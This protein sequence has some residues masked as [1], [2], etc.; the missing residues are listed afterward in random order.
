MTDRYLLDE[1]QRLFAADKVAAAARARI[2]QGL[3][4]RRE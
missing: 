1:H 4:R 2:E 3:S